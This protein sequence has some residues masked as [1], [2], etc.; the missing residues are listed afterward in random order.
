MSELILTPVFSANEQRVI[1]R[2]LRLLEKYQRHPGEQFL[3]TTFTKVWLQLNLA[4]QE[5]EAFMVLY[6][7]NQNRL[8]AY[9]TLALGTINHVEVYPREIVKSALRH[10]AAAVIL[11]HNHP[12]G[13]TEVSRQDKHITDQIIKALALVDVR[14]L[15]H[16]IVGAGDI[17]SFAECG[18]L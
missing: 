18:W 10:N 5:R 1:R 7:D 16:F 8:L 2:A 14:V 13:T 9:E 4:Q 11:A 12:S 6:L 3:A 17:V 15:D